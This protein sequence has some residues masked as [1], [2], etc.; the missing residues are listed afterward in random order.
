MNQNESH[1]CGSLVSRII[2]SLGGASNRRNGHE[3]VANNRNLVESS[4]G[5]WSSAFQRTQSRC[6][7]DMKVN[8]ALRGG[9]ELFTTLMDSRDHAHRADH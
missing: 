2:I 8:T 5:F 7:L 1:R 4:V 6:S 3:A 9:F